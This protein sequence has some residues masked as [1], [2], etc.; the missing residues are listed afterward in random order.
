M[1]AV[2]NVSSTIIE[3][4]A[5]GPCPHPVVASLAFNCSLTRR[6]LSTHAATV[7]ALTTAGR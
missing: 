6:M 5:R 7:S 2:V 3:R 4:E 1:D